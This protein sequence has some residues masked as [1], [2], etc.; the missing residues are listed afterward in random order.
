MESYLNFICSS[1]HCLLERGW[2]LRIMNN[3]IWNRIVIGIL[4]DY[5]FILPEWGRMLLRIINSEHRFFFF[6]GVPI[7]DF[8]TPSWFSATFDSSWFLRYFFTCFFPVYYGA[9]P[10]SYYYVWFWLISHLSCLHTMK[11]IA[12]RC[13]QW[14]WGLAP[15]LDDEKKKK[16]S[17]IIY[18]RHH[19]LHII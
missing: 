7:I 4:F 6:R 3:N 8:F 14:T 11:F 15:L 9:P 5:L 16:S 1:V 19:A 10:E 13:M 2:M 17:F 12:I 18:T